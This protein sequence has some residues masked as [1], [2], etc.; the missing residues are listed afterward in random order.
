[1]EISKL[2]LA[3]Q[4]T[5]QTS[6]VLG[7]ENS[8]SKTKSSSVSNTV[9]SEVDTHDLSSLESIKSFVANA[10]QASRSSY[11]ASLKDA[12]ENGT[13][14]PSTNS[15]VSAMFADGTVEALL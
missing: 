2:L 7:T 6:S 15:I 1:M 11:I 14:N 12:V 4:N 10:K 8:K 9:L 3:S 13:Y 5:N